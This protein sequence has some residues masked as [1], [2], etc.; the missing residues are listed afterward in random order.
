M[1]GR[2][3]IRCRIEGTD[4][5]GGRPGLA[6][7]R[8]NDQP[9]TAVADRATHNASK[10][11]SGRC[12]P[13]GRRVYEIDGS[14]VSNP[15]GYVPAEA[16]LG[17]FAVGLDG[18]PTGDYARNPGHGLVRDDFAGWRLPTIGWAGC[19]T[20]PPRRFVASSRR[21]LRTRCQ[22]RPWNG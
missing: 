20:R 8:D 10:P 21:L 12:C 9:A 15:D 14:I 13:P 11:D 7:L 19:R 6:R 4:I 2:R 1:T 17:G 3:G 22:D 18:R 16:I 5:A